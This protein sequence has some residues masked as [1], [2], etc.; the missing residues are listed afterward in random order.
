M[1]VKKKLTLQETA[2]TM[3][4]EELNIANFLQKSL[5]EIKH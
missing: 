4:N 1:H 2:Q 3:T 5:C